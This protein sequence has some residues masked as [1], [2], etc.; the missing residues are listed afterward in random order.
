MSHRRVLSLIE[1]SIQLR[2]RLL[3]S[4]AFTHQTRY[5][6]CHHFNRPHSKRVRVSH[7][8]QNRGKL[9]FFLAVF[10]WHLTK[11]EAPAPHHSVVQESPSQTADDVANKSYRVTSRLHVALRVLCLASSALHHLRM[12][13]YRTTRTNIIFRTV[14]P[15][16]EILAYCG[17]TVLLVRAAVVERSTVAHQKKKEKMKEKTFFVVVHPEPRRKLS[18]NP[19]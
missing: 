14:A 8:F 1:H 15:A 19:P 11:G 10:F 18:G 16:C 6:L 13:T 4:N 2:F 5:F 12:D 7:F 3:R 17:V 9:S